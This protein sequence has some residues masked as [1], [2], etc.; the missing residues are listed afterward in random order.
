LIRRGAAVRFD[1]VAECGRNEPLRVLVE[2]DDDGSEL[3]V[4]LKPSGRP[5]VGIEGMAN[6]LLAACVAGHVGLPVCEPVVVELSP[7]WIAS[8]PSV[9]LREMLKRSCPLAFASRSAGDG[10]RRWTRE[11][12]LG[13]ERR[14]LALGIFAFDVF[15]ENVD[16][17]VSN[18]NLLI[19][20]DEFRIIDHELCFG[21][22]MKL[23]PR[24]E[25]WREGYLEA[26]VAPG[27]DAHVF[28]Q[29]LKGDRYID[30]PALRPAWESLSDE[31]L[32]DYGAM[33]PPEWSE[34]ANAV[35][36]GLTHLAQVRDR[37][38]ECLTEVKR[39]L[40]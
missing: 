15:T 8:I 21:L 5:E 38:D 7:E 22:R 12:R 23:F 28:G 2:M 24:P 40:T 1:R 33:L 26:R 37:I 11:D 34:A 18:P 14:P 25:P 17:L 6:E 13:G 9:S 35:T 16:R 32:T 39:A 27:G 30:I 20:G 3:E 29:L 36:D 19:R 4:F 10:W 31:V